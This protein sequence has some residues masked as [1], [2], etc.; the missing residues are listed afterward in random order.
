MLVI[1]PQSPG[2]D[3]VPPLK[4]FRFSVSSRYPVEL[5]PLCSDAMIFKHYLKTEVKPESL[6]GPL[7]LVT[8]VAGML[9]VVAY[10]DFG[11]FSSNQTG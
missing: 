9:D 7:L 1:L 2:S 10:A 11:T 3:S 4:G 8:I 5:E 6:I